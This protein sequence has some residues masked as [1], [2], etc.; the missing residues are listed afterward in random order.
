[1]AQALMTSGGLNF[2]VKRAMLASPPTSQSWIGWGTGTGQG[3]ASVNLATSASEARVGGVVSTPD[4]YMSMQY[5]GT[6]TAAGNKSI[7]E[8]GLFTSSDVLDTMTAYGSFTAVAVS[9]NDQIQ[10]T[11]TITST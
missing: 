2:I 1:M 3:T 6:I 10:F 9:T 8:A 5:V 4:A 7:T 11:F